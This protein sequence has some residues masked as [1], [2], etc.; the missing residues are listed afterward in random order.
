MTDSTLTPDDVKKILAKN[1]ITSLD[2]LADAIA[3]S[4]KTNPL[5]PDINPLAD[6]WVIKVWKLD[7][8][9]DQIPDDVGGDILKNKV[10]GAF[11]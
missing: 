11:K 7:K 5:D 6:S 9:I 4:Q 8:E 2:D 10:Q 1:G 3:A